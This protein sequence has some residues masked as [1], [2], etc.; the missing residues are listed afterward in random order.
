VTD[1]LRDLER[2]VEQGNLFAHAEMTKQA[3][4]ANESEALLNG[5]VGLLVRQKVVDADE[6]MAIV[7]AARPATERNVEVA[8]RTDED[9]TEPTIDCASRLPV[10][11]AVCCRL[12][13]ALSV[14]EIEAG[15]MKW[16]LGRPYFNRHN[17]DGYCHQWDNGCT[18][19]EDRPNPC[20]VYS[21]EHDDRIW[22][23]FEAMELNHEW[24]ARYLVKQAGPVEL[25]MESYKTR[26][27]EQP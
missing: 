1:P 24:I 20:R 22:K 11:K 5:L 16:E 12:H 17:E 26:N 21:C 19:Y 23:D 27:G 15:L 2:Q 9:L 10:C 7:E 25:F 4:R 6:L 18:V 8:V 13:F 14:E 3:A